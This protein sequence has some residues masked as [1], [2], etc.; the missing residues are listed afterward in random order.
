MYL[1]PPLHTAMNQVRPLLSG[2]GMLAS[3]GG[4]AIGARRIIRLVTIRSVIADNKP[5]SIA[6]IIDSRIVIIF[7]DI[8][9]LVKRCQLWLIYGQNSPD[10]P[11]IIVSDK[12]SYQLLLFYQSGTELA[13]PLPRGLPTE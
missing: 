3:K 4:R 1:L 12:G 9:E 8:D 2:L 7:M 11:P 10:S 13:K 5:P 6:H